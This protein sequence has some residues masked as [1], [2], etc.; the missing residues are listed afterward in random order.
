MRHRVREIG[1]LSGRYVCIQCSEHFANWTDAAEHEKRPR[2]RNLLR[3][4]R[5]VTRY[6]IEMV[7]IGARFCDE[8]R[9]E[10]TPAQITRAVMANRREQSADVCHTHDYCDANEP[11]A[12]AFRRVMGRDCDPLS[13]RDS[14]VWAGAWDLAKL[15]EF[16]LTEEV[17]DAV[18]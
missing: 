2:E 14:T 6:T 17:L 5:E 13:D 3:P 4:G 7:R 12:A 8:L 10:L 16:N 15:T 1:H 9:Q 11:M 18:R